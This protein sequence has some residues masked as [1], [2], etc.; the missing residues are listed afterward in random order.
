MP[1]TKSTAAFYVGS[2]KASAVYVGSTLAWS[3]AD[4]TPPAAPTGLTVTGTTPSSVTLSWT[5]ATDNVAVTG[6]RVFK[7]GAQVGTTTT[8]TYTATALKPTTSYTFTVAAYDG[9]GNVSAQ[10]ASVTGTTT[11]QPDTV[12]P[13]T[14]TNFRVVSTTT[15]SATFA[16]TAATDNVG[17]DQY[18][19]YSSNSSVYPV[20]PAGTATSAT[21]NGLASNTSY[22]F[23]LLAYDAAGNWSANAGPILASTQAVVSYPFTVGQ[24]TIGT[25]K[26]GSD[27]YGSWTQPGSY[28]ITT[29]NLSSA[30]QYR[31][32][33]YWY[34]DSSEPYNNGTNALY[35]NGYV[36]GSVSTNNGSVSLP[37]Q[38]ANTSGPSY[39]QS[40]GTFYGQGTTTFYVQ[41]T[42]SWYAGAYGNP[43]LT[44]TCVG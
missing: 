43:G 14:P 1:D 29:V 35:N 30:R 44:I 11:S 16:W 15:S 32:S 23:Y 31:I 42:D 6:Y 5:A 9:A 37:S 20:F 24:Y 26:N 13:S 22:S 7:G 10:S 19:V 25:P 41:I 38:R 8:T 33:A 27:P 2:G 40:S 4:T 17:V 21:V 28:A 39:Q 3:A 18:Q 36:V 12:P 34:V